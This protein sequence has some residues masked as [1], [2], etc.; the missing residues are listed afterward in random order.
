MG[1]M[2]P[3]KG[4]FDLVPILR[5]LNH[6]SV[7]ARLTIAG[8][9]H[10]ALARRFT[11]R[12]LDHLVVWK[13]RVPHE[14]CFRLASEHDVLLMPT[15]KEAFGMVTIEAMSMGCVPVA[16]DIPSGT[17]EIIANGQSG[18][19][20]SL[21]DFRACAEAIKLLNENRDQLQALSQR[22]MAR[23]RSEFSAQAM[24]TQLYAFLTRL[25]KHALANPSERKSAP[26]PE[27]VSVKPRS[28]RY[29]RLPPFV[30]EWLRNQ[31]GAR[32]R[33]SYWLLNHWY[34]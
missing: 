17:T 23:A 18:V 5:R 24:A 20:V 34:Q 12:K 26:P 31:V 3:F 30:R 1:R 28:L 22:A 21:G 9:Q 27:I 14:E 32:P 2:D 4:I 8:G 13:G 15:R 16:Y 6:W 10:E 11:Q 33:L 25:Q 19:L 7:P 29:N